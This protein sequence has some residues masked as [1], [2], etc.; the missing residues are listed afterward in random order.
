M[1]RNPDRKLASAAR[2]LYD[3]VPRGR[4]HPE[5]LLRARAGIRPGDRA[6][7]RAARALVRGDGMAAGRLTPLVRRQ[8]IDL[9]VGDNEPLG[10]YLRE[11][12]HDALAGPGV[13]VAKA[14]EIGKRDF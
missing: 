5:I 13:L 4:P 3:G 11:V 6:G 7:A 2:G 9:G 14:L 1:E 8:Q 10:Q 12:A